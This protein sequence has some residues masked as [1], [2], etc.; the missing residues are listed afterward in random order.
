MWTIVW[1][2]SGVQL[3]TGG[4]R[5][6][7]PA[8]AA[9]SPAAAASA[10]PARASPAEKSL[11]GGAFLKAFPPTAHPVTP[12]PSRSFQKP[13]EVPHPSQPSNKGRDAGVTMDA[14]LLSRGS[15]G[16]AAPTRPPAVA[17][18][19]AAETLVETPVDV[20]LARARGPYKKAF[21]AFVQGERVK[22]LMHDPYSYAPAA[23][24][25]EVKAAEA[26][27]WEQ[28][29]SKEEQRQL[30][31]SA[32]ASAEASEGEAAGKGGGTWDW[33]SGAF[34]GQGGKE[35]S[36]PPSHDHKKAKVPL[37]ARKN[38]DSAELACEFEADLDYLGKDVGTVEGLSDQ[39]CC[40]LCARKT[41]DVAVMSSDYD[42]PPRACWLKTKVRK[43][44]S[45]RGVRACWPANH[46][47]DWMDSR[48]SDR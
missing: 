9:A 10:V 14:V 39:E 29:G 47:K 38:S 32:S 45:K 43:R 48:S 27:V 23:G 28:V 42:E 36:T 6:T 11:P 18:A 44:V 8:V 40:E 25:K 19:V 4:Q 15:P 21:E 22:E 33:F 24:S 2:F 7:V 34:S 5:H 12:S 3:H 13:A 26:S 35:D 37:L 20:L 30:L 46:K 31:G 16:T 17:A 41:C 1:L